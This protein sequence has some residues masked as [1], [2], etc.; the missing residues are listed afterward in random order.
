VGVLIQARTV[1]VLMV[2]VLLC[3][4]AGLFCGLFLVSRSVP[5]WL[6]W[7]GIG[8]YGLLFAGAIVR[9]LAPA[10]AGI[11]TPA[12]VPGILFEIAIGATLLGRSRRPVA[13][14]VA[15]GR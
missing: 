9:L 2:L 5:R 12:F 7:W 3:V 4:G 8:S 11:T 10:A 14:E 13:T 15:A 6:A 1:G